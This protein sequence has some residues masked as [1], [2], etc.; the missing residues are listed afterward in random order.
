M[1]DTTIASN[2]NI[3]YYLN[4]EKF[5]TDFSQEDILMGFDLYTSNEFNILEENDIRYQ[6]AELGKVD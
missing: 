4:H 1:K 3:K 5:I 2:F 6:V